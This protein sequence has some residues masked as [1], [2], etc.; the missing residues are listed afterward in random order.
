M[1]NEM[2]DYTSDRAASLSQVHL[3]NAIDAMIREETPSHG[4]FSFCLFP[5]LVHAHRI[6]ATR[7]SPV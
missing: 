4:I 2:D 1:G 5:Y 7:P 3:Y 6:H